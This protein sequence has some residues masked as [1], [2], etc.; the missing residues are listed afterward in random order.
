MPDT[1]PPPIRRALVTGASSG[2]GLAYAERLA[3]D[4]YEVLAL[5][6]RADRLSALA[7]RL[8]RTYGVKV[9]VLVADLSIRDD[10][11]AVEER[12]T[13]DPSL[14]VLVNNAGFTPLRTFDETPPD[15][16]EEMIQVHVTALT[17][18]SRAVLPGMMERRH[19]V[20]INV[21]SDGVFVTYPSPVMVAYAATKAYVNTFTLG[22]HSLA[23][24]YGVRVQAVCPGYVRSEILERH[25]ITFEEWGIPDSVVMTAEEMV[26][27]SMAALQQGEIVCVPSLDDATLLDRVEET[28][29][30]IRERSSSTGTPAP[31]YGL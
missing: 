12:V 30:V 15:E 11:R 2:I 6:R 18:L 7:E 16:I 27:A 21:S 10:L 28:N 9:E 25:G 24:E 17:R 20:I 26:D 4:G 31:R 1:S 29:S 14:V 5:G 8:Q 3:R 22:L 23:H 13:V 19:G